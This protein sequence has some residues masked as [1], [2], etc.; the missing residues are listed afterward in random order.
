MR[1]KGMERWRTFF[2]VLWIDE[3]NTR[4]GRER[5]GREREASAVSESEEGKIA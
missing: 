2:P 5:E 4:E 1:W 3:G